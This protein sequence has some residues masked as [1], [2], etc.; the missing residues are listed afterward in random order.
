MSVSLPILP[1]KS[2]VPREQ[3]PANANLC[4]YCT[5]R[6]CRYIALPIDEP[7]SWKDFDD[8][9][10]YLMHDDIGLFVDEENWYIMIHRDCRHIRDD[11]KCGLYMDRPQICRDYKT[12]DCEYEDLYTYDKIFENDAQIWEYAEAVLG[13]REVRQPHAG[14]TYQN[15]K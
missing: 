6:C 9:R 3:I 5:A 4:D 7:T 10:W 1:S 13:P 12:D 8:L 11:Y 15:R 2:I 14:E